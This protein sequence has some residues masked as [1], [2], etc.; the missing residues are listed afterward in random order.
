MRFIQEQYSYIFST[1][2]RSVRFEGNRSVTIREN[3]KR[4][5]NKI[6]K[7]SSE[8]KI[9]LSDIHEI[10]PHEFFN[11]IEQ[12]AIDLAKQQTQMI[13]ETAGR[14][15]E[16]TG[17]VINIKKGKFTINT[18]FKMLDKIQLD[19][20]ENTKKPNLPSIVAGEET[21]KVLAKEFPQLESNAYYKKKFE[22]IINKKYIE[23]NDRENNRELVG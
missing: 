11:S 21:F 4:Q 5:E 16:R 2:P 19:F 10:S 1:V 17:N 15:A 18:F 23:W 13:L 12:A 8:I 7:M 6:R 20:D 9:N 14:S 3:G 22:R